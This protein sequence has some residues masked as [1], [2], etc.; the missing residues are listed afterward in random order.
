[1]L[2]LGWAMGIKLTHP[3]LLLPSR[4]SI[5]KDSRPTLEMKG[6]VSIK[7]KFPQVYK[8]FSSPAMEL[9]VVQAFQ[10]CLR[11][12]IDCIVHRFL[13]LGWGRPTVSGTLRPLQQLL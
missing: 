4:K 13:G 8:V 12:G 11:G 9:P 2:P 5:P 10:V 1:M 3:P 6:D 7:P